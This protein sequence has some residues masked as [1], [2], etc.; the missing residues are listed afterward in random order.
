MPRFC[1]GVALC[2]ARIFDDVRPR[3]YLSRAEMLM[4]HHLFCACDGDDKEFR[5]R[6]NILMRD[7]LITY[8]SLI[9]SISMSDATPPV[10][11]HSSA[12]LRA[13]DA[14]RCAVAMR[15]CLSRAMR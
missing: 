15:R 6:Y 7:A 13:L 3:F 14:C 10:T 11:Q 12:S 9:S 4:R 1:R 2:R 5:A 8:M